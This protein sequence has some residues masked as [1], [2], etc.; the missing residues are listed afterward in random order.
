MSNNLSVWQKLL[1][2]VLIPLSFELVFVVSLGGLLHYAQEESDRYE[3]SKDILLHFHMSE[4]HL[5]HVMSSFIN[6]STEPTLLDVRVATAESQFRKICNEI[7]Y[8]GPVR[9]ELRQSLE[10]VPQLFEQ[11][12]AVTQH[13]KKVLNSRGS[14]EL[15]DVVS[16]R[17]QALPLLIEFQR[18]SQDVLR[19]E[20]KMSTVAPE[21]LAKI[22][23]W[24]ICA[25]VFGTLFS[26]TL[27]ALASYIFT[28]TILVRLKKIENNAH[29]LG[30]REPLSPVPIGNDE[31]GDLAKSLQAAELVLA[32]TR[33][34]ELAILDVAADVICSFD[35]RYRFTAVG[36]SAVSSWGYPLNELFGTSMLSLQTKE[37]ESSC[38]TA[39]ELIARS[40][41]DGEFETQLVCK[42]GNL[43]DMLWKV[44]W[45]TENANFYCVAHD[46]TERRA[47]DR[48]KQRFIAIVSHDLR[49]P[50][51]SVSAT[52]SLLNRGARGVLPKQVESILSKAEQSLERLMDLIR[53]LLDLEK[54]EAGKVVMELRCV[55]AADICSAARDSVEYLAKSLDVKIILP[56]G[57]AAILGDERRLVRVLI[58]LIS[59]AVKFSPRGATVTVNL[60]HLGDFTEITVIDQ[61]PG[62]P[63]CDRELIFE[64]FR[65]SK[66]KSTAAIKGTGLGLA[67]SKFIVEGHNGKISCESHDGKGSKFTVSIPNFKDEETLS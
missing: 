51:S 14:L 56:H 4:S 15:K 21:E 67:I 19:A 9:P 7:K 61:G 31:I 8:S 49:T 44:S 65:Q 46:I 12:I 17:K 27:S 28:S 60:K 23:L 47:A 66:T 63:E 48:M 62:V 5:L 25:L 11:A 40:G 26:V 45:L 57:D 37:S 13:T 29:H 20:L 53:D 34:K 35:H 52:L 55:S 36:A 33:G 41:K 54:L 2:V 42:N 58:N 30:F 43:K 24:V 1:L 3:K 18:I 50:L 64:K 39:L 32:E 10:E 16:I 59:N 22:R 6:H 38:R